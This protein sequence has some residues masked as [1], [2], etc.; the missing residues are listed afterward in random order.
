[1]PRCPGRDWRQPSSRAGRNGRPRT[2]GGMTSQQRS[3]RTLVLA[4]AADLLLVLVF[5]LI[6][7]DSHRE[8]FSLGGTATTFW[9]FLVG[10]VLGWL[11]TRAWR[12]PLAVVGTGVGV[13]VI[14]VV[15][16]MLL[17]LASSQGVQFSFV[18]VTAIVLGVF[19]VG[20]RGIASLVSR[21]R[22]STR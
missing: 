12:A 2:L 19:L 11:A 7:R 21:R 9:P 3:T 16:G 5:V 18:I 17:R 14:T 4:G 20:W 22:R 15:V 6:G 10:L 8:G 1:M 13:W